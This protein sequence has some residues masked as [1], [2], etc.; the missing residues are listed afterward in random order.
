MFPLKDENPTFHR[1]LITYL[2][3]ALNILSWIFIQKLGTHPGLMK[4]IT[5]F[6]LIPGDL[7]GLVKSGTQIPLGKGFTYILDGNPDWLTPI[8]SMFMH[9]GWLHLIGNMWFLGIFGD[10]I[11]DLLGPVKF[12]IFYIFCGLCAAAAQIAATPASPIPMVGASGAIGGVMGA[13]AI[14]FP[15]APVH[16][17]V[18]FG[19]F[20]TRIVVPAFFMLGYW[21]LLQ[22]LGGIFSSGMGGVAFGRTS[23]DFFLEL[24][25][26]RFFVMLKE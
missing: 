21:F 24:Y 18:F 8:S 9:G 16:M 4:S 15:R 20:L 26:L 3:I 11:E 5:Q 17:L 1:S 25:L 10:N 22:L 7:L 23:V 19:F 2:I 14:M 6:G 13:Y 12:I